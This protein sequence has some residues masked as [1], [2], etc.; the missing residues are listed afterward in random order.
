MWIVAGRRLL[1]GEEDL[2]PPRRDSQEEVRLYNLADWVP[3]E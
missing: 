3:V 1:P 2:T